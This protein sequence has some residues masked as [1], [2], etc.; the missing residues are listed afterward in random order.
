MHDSPII[1]VGGIK[2]DLSIILMLLVTC[3]IVFVIARLATRKLSV[4]NPGKMQNA[5][6]LGAEFIKDLISSTMDMKKGKV[7]V[8]L[9]MTII[10]FV[11]IGN[12]LG[13]PFTIVTEHHETQTVLGYELQSTTKD[14]FDSL[15]AK[16]KD[17]HSEIVWWKSPT[18]DPNVTM[19][20]AFMIFFLTH[21]LGLTRNTK[22]YF[23]HYI[24]PSPLF[25][26]INIIEQFTKLVTHGMRLFGNV[27]A[28]E[29][30][31][32]VL[33]GFGAFAIPGIIAWQAFGLFISGIQAFVFTILT[34]VYISQ[35]IESHDH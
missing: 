15:E 29:V 27:F 26:P 32:T 19:G 17:P 14:H 20:L 18:A 22:G 35:M 16:G 2:F 25:L 1:L 6:E 21:F 28:K 3:T 9:G 31:M 11:F 33:V 4:D 5:L 30:L 24:E 7:F 8:S 13:L 34:M 23:K 10:I 12:L